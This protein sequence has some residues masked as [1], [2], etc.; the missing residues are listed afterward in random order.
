MQFNILAAKNGL[1]RTQLNLKVI[2]EWLAAQ[3]RVDRTI[4][5]VVPVEVSVET[6]TRKINTRQFARLKKLQALV[7]GCT[8][9]NA[10]S[11]V[12]TY[13]ASREAEVLDFLAKCPKGSRKETKKSRTTKVYTAMD[14]T[15][16]PGLKAAKREREGG[17]KHARILST[18][19]RVLTEE[20][21]TFADLFLRL[22][23]RNRIPGGFNPRPILRRI[24]NESGLFNLSFS[25]TYSIRDRYQA[26]PVSEPEPQVEIPSEPEEETILAEPEAMIEES[27]PQVEAPSVSETNVAVESEES[28]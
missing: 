25:D 2:R 12:L 3:V 19:E 24:L 26:E 22:K 20:P 16:K 10:K 13:P 21:L 5:V 27:K 8:V 23:T 14:P 4:E 15:A 7:P 1:S 18:A 6:R 28:S 11:R 17:T 9:D